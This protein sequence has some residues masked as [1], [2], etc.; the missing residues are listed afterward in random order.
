MFMTLDQILTDARQL[1]REQA[2]ELLDRLL[3]DTLGTPDPEI[4]K[5]WVNETRYRIANIESGNVP[6]IAGDEVMN[7]LRRLV[8]R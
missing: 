2:A 1:S 3:A 7:E 4:E 6:G 5:A 8:G